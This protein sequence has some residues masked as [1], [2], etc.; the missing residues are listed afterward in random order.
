[1]SKKFGKN[2]LLSESESESE[3]ELEIELTKKDTEN[4]KNFFLNLDRNSTNGKI[5]EQYLKFINKKTNSNF[6]KFYKNKNPEL[7]Y[8]INKFN[9]YINEQDIIKKKE[10][11]IQD[12]N[13]YKSYILEKDFLDDQIILLNSLSFTQKEKDD[14]LLENYKKFI[15]DVKYFR[16]KF[17][18]DPPTIQYIKNRLREYDNYVLNIDD[19][20]KKEN[21]IANS[22]LITNYGKNEY[23]V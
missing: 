2:I 13:K 5:Y 12:Q 1:M 20:S 6:K 22:N 19:I 16:N 11:E 21:Y 7:N 8:V 23:S 4:E 3:S 18:N 14:I 9:E 10:I 17:K 15:K